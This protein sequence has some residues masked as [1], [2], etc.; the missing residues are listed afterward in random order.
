MYSL[1][2]DN[3]VARSNTMDD[4]KDQVVDVNLDD[5][6][7]DDDMFKSARELEPEPEKRNVDL[8]GNVNGNVISD[9]TSLGTTDRE[10]PLEDEDEK[11]FQV[12]D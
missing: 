2:D 11:P 12:I 8:F 1:D 3:Q 10:I 4:F 5:N 9:M 6:D 7:N